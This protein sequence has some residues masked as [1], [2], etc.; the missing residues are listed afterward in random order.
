MTGISS[1][2]KEK[3]EINKKRETR[4]FIN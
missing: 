1:W 3:N 4:Y 2:E